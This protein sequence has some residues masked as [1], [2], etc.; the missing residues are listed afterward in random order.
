MGAWIHCADL[1]PSQD[2]GKQ[3]FVTSPWRFRFYIINEAP[4]Q[5]STVYYVQYLIIFFWFWTS[6]KTSIKNKENLLHVGQHRRPTCSGFG[7]VEYISFAGGPRPKIYK[8]VSNKLYCLGVSFMVCNMNIQEICRK[9]IP[10][11]W[12]S[13]KS[14]LW[15]F[16]WHKVISWHGGHA[17]SWDKGAAPRLIEV[18][19]CPGGAKQK[20]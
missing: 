17:L 12:L 5:Y 9:S 14:A 10:D 18:C 19:S 11:T 20:H 8:P 7:G 4:K 16:S 15:F 3:V 6:W 2:V 13:D 1:S